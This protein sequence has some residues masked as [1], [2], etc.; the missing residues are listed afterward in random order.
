MTTAGAPRWEHFEHG[1]D[2]GVRGVGATAAQAFEQAALALT[3]VITDPARV[4]P[5]DAVDFACEAAD[6]ELLLTQWLNALV[7][8]MAVRHML[9]ARF[10]VVIDDGPPLRLRARAFGEPVDVARHH[11]AVEV[12]GATYTALRVARTA[13]GGWLA[14][15]VV[16]V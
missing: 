6:L 7:Y 14:Q 15:T 4:V 16:D 1:A 5:R 13:D 10:D 2:V 9:F 12:K 11:P 3:A 8:E